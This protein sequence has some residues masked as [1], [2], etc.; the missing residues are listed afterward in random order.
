MRNVQAAQFTVCSSGC[1]STTIQGGI[2]LASNGD[3]VLITDS[4]WYN[5]NVV[6]GKLILL[7][8]NS[9]I[10]PTINSTGTTLRIIANSVIVTNLTIAYN[11]TAT[12]QNVV[13][14]TG[15]YTII[16]NNTIRMRNQNINFPVYIQNSAGNIIYGNNITALSW[17]NDAIYITGSSSTN[18]TIDSNL[19]SHAATCASGIDVGANNNTIKNNNITSV[20]GELPIFLR[21]YYNTA[22]I[23]NNYVNGKP[24]VYNKSLSNEIIKT[25]DYGELIVANSFN[26]TINESSFTETGILFIRTSNSTI[27]NS[28]INTKTDAIVFVD[29]SD[30]NTIVNNNISTSGGDRSYALRLIYGNYLNITNNNITTTGAQYN[31]G[32]YSED[33][34]D[35]NTIEAN[36]IKTVG[37]YGVGIYLTGGSSNH[38]ITNTNI[39]SSGYGANGIRLAGWNNVV[40]SCKITTSGSSSTSS[41]TSTTPAFPPALYIRAG[42]NNRISNCILNAINYYDIF[43]S[44]ISNQINYLINTTFN[45]TDIKFN[46]SS[47]TKLY[48]QYYLDVKVQD[49]SNNPIDSAT[50][51]GNDVDAVANTENPTSAFT[52][53]TNAS[54]YTPQQTLTEFLGNWTF[55]STNGY[56]YFTNYTINTSKIGYRNNSIQMNITS[57]DF[58][59]ITLQILYTYQ[60]SCGWQCEDYAGYITDSSWSPGVFSNSTPT[61]FGTCGICTDCENTYWYRKYV[62]V[63]PS[64]NVYLG[65]YH[66]GSIKIYVNGVEVFTDSGEHSHYLLLDSLS[67]GQKNLITVKVATW[68]GSGKFGGDVIYA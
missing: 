4:R 63:P 61:I 43:A 38:K 23:D 41:D 7:S 65:F 47:N 59:L 53:V 21:A 48:N 66:T 58:E 11:G 33:S 20:G 68:C 35:Y 2:T 64:A 29:L 39:T 17:C 56:L 51:I 52:A 45:K 19:I 18:N 6:V 60:G 62:T 50:V 34:S 44:G 5:E 9:S 49:G 8:S 57:S 13:W 16:A 24:I 28:N 25:Q 42:G 31:F 37:S 3:T 32:I 22:V 10:R 30:N 27:S 67:H 15:S 46:D 26:I 40:T 36:T 1:D 55:N 54:G 14:I 12:N